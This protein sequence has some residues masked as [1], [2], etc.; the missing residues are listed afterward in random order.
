LSE[1][2]EC[3]SVAVHCSCKDGINKQKKTQ[4]Y[5]KMGLH[6]NFWGYK[7]RAKPTLSACLQCWWKRIGM[8]IMHGQN[9]DR[10][11]RSNDVFVLFI[12]TVSKQLN[13]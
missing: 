12:R 9:D 7:W 5:R 2:Y 13:C 10:S 4:L 3:V 8:I 1:E 11:H 6:T